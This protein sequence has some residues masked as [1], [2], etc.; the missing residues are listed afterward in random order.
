MNSST[1]IRVA[2]VTLAV[3]GLTAVPVIWGS[4]AGIGTMFNAPLQWIP[5]DAAAR[6][7]FN[8]FVEQFEIHE[9]VLVSWPGCTIHDG[10]TQQVVD[11]LSSL[12][13]KAVE[14]GEEP[15]FSHIT[16]GFTLLEQL[17]QEP[18]ELSRAAA[19][20]RLRGTLVGDDGQTSCVIVT[21]TEEGSIQ[22]RRTL[23]EIRE[24]VA[25]VTGFSGEDLR[26]AG[27]PADGVATDDA[28]IR[29]LRY[30][31]LPAILISLLLCW[32]CLRSIWLTLPI[33]AIG[34]W[35]QAA[36]LAAVYFLGADM[37]A[38]L[39]VLPPLVFVL[40]VSGGVHLANYFYDETRGGATEGATT[41]ALRRAWGPCWLA[42][43]TTAI[44]LSSLLVSAVSP[45]RMFGALGAI[46]VIAAVWLLFLVVPGVMEIR[47]AM[48]PTRRVDGRVD[49]SL[50]PH[51]E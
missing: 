40:T 11:A 3:M 1:Y 51:F 23:H 2:S 25:Q 8:Q 26:I 45:I 43:I 6:Q 41:R 14:R 31:S 10:R 47:L 18:A 19:I 46:G 50:T 39:I 30:Y 7:S 33:L 35:G 5:R 21:L 12:R 28:S 20:D 15:L 37:N 22:R 34:A 27:S 29:S 44:G 13:T 9:I 48:G 4:Q 16:G 32:L 42:A 38:V 17:Q 24:T 36:V 49:W